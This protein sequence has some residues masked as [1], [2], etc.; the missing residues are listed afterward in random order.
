MKQ[1]Q[2]MDD[3]V[4]VWGRLMVKRLKHI[5]NTGR[6]KFIG[7]MDKCYAEYLANRWTPPD[8]PELNV[9]P[10]DVSNQVSVGITGDAAHQE[11]LNLYFSNSYNP[12]PGNAFASACPTP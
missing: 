11:A 5:S 3:E 9:P 7:Y 2:E 12:P 10:A 6:D 4:C 8:N 1:M